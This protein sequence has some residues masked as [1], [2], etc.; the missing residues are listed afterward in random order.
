MGRQAK[1]SKE[2]LAFPRAQRRAMYLAAY[3]LDPATRWEPFR[4]W[5]GGQPYIVRGFDARLAKAERRKVDRAFGGLL[6][7]LARGIRG[8]AAHRLFRRKVA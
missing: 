8:T 3:R 1:P 7:I 4:R 5:D 2:V 6:A